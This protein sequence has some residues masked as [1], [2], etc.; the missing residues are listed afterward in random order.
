MK[1]L[2]TYGSKRGGTEGIARMLGDA[3]AAHGIQTDVRPARRV[4]GLEGYDAVVVGGSLYGNF[5][6]RDARRFVRKHAE[7]LKQLPVWFFSSGPLDDSATKQE[8]PPVKQ[9]VGLMERV[10]ANGHQTFG[11]VMEENPK[12]FFARKLAKEHAG[13]WR[14]PSHIRRWAETIS[15]A[16]RRPERAAPE[17]APGSHDSV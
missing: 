15:A 13:D 10:G 7:E 4:H 11:G 3:F 1:L 5:W 14:D 16:V 2:V 8:I 17:P 12:G 9:V 6:H